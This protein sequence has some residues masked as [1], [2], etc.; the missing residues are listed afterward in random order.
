VRTFTLFT[1]L[2][3]LVGCQKSSK[4]P[5]PAGESPAPTAD[6]V[7]PGTTPDKGA[8][9]TS[10]GKKEEP[11]PVRYPL[12][13]EKFK[14]GAMGKTREQLVDLYGPPAEQFDPGAAVGW[15][16]P[17]N[18]Y[19]GPFTDADGKEAAKAQVYFR[20]KDGVVVVAQVGFVNK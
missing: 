5:A 17:I 11:Q 3:L 7:A 20:K 19:R 18:I 4:S 14:A 2:L 9:N 1:A 13:Q 10:A 8:P 12:D 6:Q 16:G 15:D